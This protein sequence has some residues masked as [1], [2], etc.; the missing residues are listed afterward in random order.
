M[1][2]EPHWSELSNILTSMGV[3]INFSLRGEFWGASLLRGTRG[4]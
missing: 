2:F 1:D 3:K 4:V